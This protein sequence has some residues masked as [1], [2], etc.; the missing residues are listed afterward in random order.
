M[1]FLRAAY[2]KVAEKRKTRVAERKDD[3]ILESVTPQ[4][5]P[6]Y[7]QLYIDF[8][9]TEDR[10]IHE[11]NLYT[12]KQKGTDYE[13]YIGLLFKKK[14]YRVVYNGKVKGSHDRGRDLICHYKN[15]TILVQCK[16]YNDK[17][18]I[19]IND[20]YQFYGSVRHYAVQNPKEI[21]CGEMWTSTEIDNGAR[22]A[23]IDLGILIHD[24]VVMPNLELSK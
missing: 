4:V 17:T 1:P 3:I 6:E 12:N 19:S 24:A 7:G 5:L 8:G 9:E 2:L 15:Y 21:V 23:A 16:Y 18:K 10:E 14:G 11:K 20:I 22:E 13:E